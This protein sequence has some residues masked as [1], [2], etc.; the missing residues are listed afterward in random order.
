[1]DKIHLLVVVAVV[2][3]NLDKGLDWGQTDTIIK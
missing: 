2:E 1:M 3:D